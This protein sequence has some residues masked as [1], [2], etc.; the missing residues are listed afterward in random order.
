MFPIGPIEGNTLGSYFLDLGPIQGNA[1][2]RCPKAFPTKGP[3]WPKIG[4]K[5]QN[6]L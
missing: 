6:I 4:P 1:F 2:I 3:I 5:S